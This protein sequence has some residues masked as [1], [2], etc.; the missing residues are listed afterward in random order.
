MPIMTAGLSSKREI[1]I[2]ASVAPEAVA[3]IRLLATHHRA[4]TAAA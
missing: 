4:L 2:A 3:H 1:W